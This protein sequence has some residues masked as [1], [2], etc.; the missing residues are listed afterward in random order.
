MTQ[1]L[2]CN[3]QRCWCERC[4]Q[5]LQLSSDKW[6]KFFSP[7]ASNFVTLSSA[8]NQLRH[9]R[10]LSLHCAMKTRFPVHL[11]A[12][13]LSNCTT[14]LKSKWGLPINPVFLSIGVNSRAGLLWNCYSILL[15]DRLAFQNNKAYKV[16]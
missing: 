16:L 5:L 12:S 8:N 14:L 10:I 7:L 4:S 11:S 3:W 9:M 1:P 2:I 6:K 13:W 15:V